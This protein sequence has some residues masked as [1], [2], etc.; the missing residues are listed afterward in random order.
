VKVTLDGG[1]VITLG[2]TEAA[3]TIGITDYSRRVTDDYGVTTVVERG[4]AR[5]MSVRLALPFSSADAVQRRLA[6]LRASPALW[7]A[8]DRYQSLKVRGFYKDFSIDLA[9]PPLSYC[10]LTVEGLAETDVLADS[11]ADPAPGGRS[12]LQLLQPVLVTPARL[13]FT[14]VPEADYPGWAAG[15]TYPLGARVIQAHRIYES[16]AAGNVGH[17]PVAQTG[18][19]I[20]IAPTNRWAMFDQALGTATEATGSISVTINPGSPVN[21]VALLDVVGTSVR[22]Q[23]SGYDRTVLLAS[24]PGTVTFLDMPATSGPVAV[25]ISGSGPVSVGT[26]LLGPLAGL[27]TTEAAPSAAI[28]DYSRKDTDEFG[29]VTVVERAWAK[30]MSV[31]ALLRSDGLDDVASRITAVRARPSLWIGSD[32]VETLTIYGFFKTFSI[33]VGEAVSRLS[34]EVEG[35]SK[36]AKIAP[37]GSAIDWPDLADPAGTKPDDNATKGAPVNTKVADIPAENVSDVLKAIGLT[38][39]PAGVVAGAQALA[40]AVAAL[41]L[42]ANPAEIVAG[43]K[44]LVDRSRSA[45]MAAL[46]Q[47]ILNQE[48]KERFDALT[49]VDGVEM[50]TVVKTETTER[51]EGDEALAQRSSVIEASVASNQAAALARIT[52]EE[53]TRAAADLAEATTRAAQVATLTTG[54]SDASAAITAEATTRAA[55]DA[56]EA[57]TRASQIATLTTGIADASAAISAEATTRAAADAAETTAR[58]LAVSNLQTDI[59]NNTAGIAAEATTRATAD[60][61]ETAARILALSNVQTNINGQIATV[62]ASIS[63]EATTRATADAAETTQRQLDVS[64]LTTSIA[65]EIVNRQ[66]AIASESTTRADAVSAEAATRAAQIA[67]LTT[68]LSDANAAISAEATTRATADAA[69]ATAR[70][71][72]AATLTGT[73]NSVS[74]AVTAETSARVA[75]DL[76]ETDAR[77]VAISALQTTINGQIASANAAIASEASTRAAADAAETSQREG[78]ISTLTTNLAAEV[79]A[80]Q[81]AITAEASTRASDIAAETTARNAQISSVTTRAAAGGPN[82]L[83]NGGLENGFATGIL[84]SGTYGYSVDPAWGAVAKASATGTQVFQFAPVSVRGGQAYTLSCDPI[85]LGGAATVYCDM[86]FYDAGGAQVLDGG[87]NV[88]TGSFDFDSTTGRRGQ[89]AI[90]TT[91]P[92]NATTVRC[93]FVASNVSGGT[94]GFRQMKLEAGSGW[95]KYTPDAA[96]TAVNAALTSEATTRATNDTAEVTA[97][98]AAV[99]TVQT[100]INT[101]SS[102]VVSETAA[103]TSADAAMAS[104]MSALQT[105]LDGHTASITFMA[106][107]LNGLSST[108]TLVQ[109]SNGKI[110]GGRGVND[111]ALSVIDFVYDRVRFWSEDGAHSTPLLEWTGDTWRLPSIEVDTIKAGTGATSQYAYVTQNNTVAGQGM[112]T[113]LTILTKNVTLLRPGHISAQAVIAAG[114]NGTI[115]NS[116]FILNIAGEGVFSGGGSAFSPTYAIGGG[117]ATPLAAGT[118]T[119]EV[120]FQGPSNMSVGSRNLSTTIIYV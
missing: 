107:S 71:A 114:L 89:I 28:I 88:L 78:A 60:A 93:R 100:N 2:A 73:I 98:Q 63:A 76:A 97:R 103:R 37:L 66:A 83:P 62:N 64:T 14:S 26:L 19:W 41:A 43:A 35:L 36:A 34:L 72:L 77:N 7:T 17:D 69:E 24:Q 46:E 74:A 22:V 29:D 15:T 106:A 111:G 119:V 52:L 13:A 65:G 61:A 117:T 45:D 70:E 4:F 96:L 57:T 67:T 109:N 101:V 3:P 85:A 59:A 86:I 27:G 33:E 95:S 58:Q 10:T 20:D 118:Y 56:A 94:V 84:S 102:A 55:A 110:S 91:A 44:S 120:I 90:T 48:R 92:S 75:A 23:A 5:R 99:A 30:R 32:G 51:I 49:H 38:I 31:N 12:T 79:T 21:A 80:R 53:T 42:T 6:G 8:D 105:T 108:F 116:N 104:Q 50:G 9:T 47:L 1:E 113:P 54:V 115:S 81:A 68:G 11:G 25:T 40:A 18:Q 87:Q 82:L 112:A 16:A 39:N